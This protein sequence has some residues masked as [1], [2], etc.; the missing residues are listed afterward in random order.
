MASAHASEAR[1]GDFESTK[2]RSH[3]ESDQLGAIDGEELRHK[4]RKDLRWRRVVMS[5]LLKYLVHRVPI[6]R[7][8]YIVG[9]DIAINNNLRNSQDDVDSML[10]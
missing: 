8:V 5:L 4:T 2:G 1:Y 10:L 3:C 6:F 7:L 9:D